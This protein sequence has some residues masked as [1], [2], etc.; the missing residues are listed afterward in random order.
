MTETPNVGVLT[1][2]VDVAGVQ[3]CGQCATIEDELATR[4]GL[5]ASE[6]LYVL[7]GRQF[8]GAVTRTVYPCGRRT[9]FDAPLTPLQDVAFPHTDGVTVGVCGCHF[10]KGVSDCTCPGVDAISLGGTPI[11]AVNQVVV[12][13]AVLADTAY[14]VR[15]FSWL[16]RIDGDGWPCCQDLDTP[17]YV[18]FTFGQAP[19]ESGVF[20][21]EVL[22]CEL[23]LACAGDGA[24]K[25]PKRVQTITRQGMTAVLL[26][27]F[28]FLEQGRTGIMEVDLFL[29][30]FNPAGL[31]EDAFVLSPDIKRPIFQRTWEA[32]S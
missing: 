17:W 31:D 20:A 27:P 3:G 19:P 25:L 9:R 23:A 5:I 12:D 16:V 4:M 2:W 29:V 14:E 6:L 13:G 1:S 11:T 7:S 28:A 10:V 24:C 21:A 32:G 30:S 8:P 18:D 15:D 22:A 26:D